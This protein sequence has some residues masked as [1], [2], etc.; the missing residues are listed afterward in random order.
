M[1]AEPMAHFAQIRLD[2]FSGDWCKLKG[3]A[4]FIKNLGKPLL[5]V[6]EKY[7]DPACEH[8]KLIRKILKKSIEMEEI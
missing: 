1:E 3:R 8:H 5:V 2:M 4:V 6:W 7:M